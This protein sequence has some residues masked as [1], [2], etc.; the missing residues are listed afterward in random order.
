LGRNETVFIDEKNVGWPYDYGRFLLKEIVQIV[1]AVRK[2]LHTS[3]TRL[4]N[5]INLSTLSR[6]FN[7]SEKNLDHQAAEGGSTQRNTKE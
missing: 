1:E 7:L 6:C 2:G 5:S 3:A 4:S